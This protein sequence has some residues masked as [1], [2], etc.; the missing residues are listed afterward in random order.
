MTHDAFF[1]HKFGKRSTGLPAELLSRFRLFL[2]VALAWGAEAVVAPKQSHP[3]NQ[4]PKRFRN[5]SKL[6]HRIHQYL[7][8]LTQQDITDQV[9]WGSN[10]V[11]NRNITCHN[12]Y[13][14]STGTFIFAHSRFSR[15]HLV[16]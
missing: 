12:P 4:C 9:Q 14:R 2:L 6:V 11:D 7:V 1:L 13:E 8:I 15:P 16:V 5:R 3:P 10:E